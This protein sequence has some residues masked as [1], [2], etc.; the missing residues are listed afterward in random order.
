MQTEEEEFV[1]LDALEEKIHQDRCHHFSSDESGVVR[2][3]GVQV[4]SCYY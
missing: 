1:D 2:E 4:A 3:R